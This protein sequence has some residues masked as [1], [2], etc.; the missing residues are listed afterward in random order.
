MEPFSK[1]LKIGEMRKISQATV[2]KAILRFI[3]H[4]LQPFSIVERTEFKDLIHD[5]Q[6]NCAVRSR[7]TIRSKI[8]DATKEMKKKVIEAMKGVEYIAT[9]TDCWS[10]RRRSFIG[11]TAHWIDPNDLNRCSAALAC[12]QLKGS[13]TFEVLANAL[14]DIHTQFE[15]R[16]KIVR[17][18][19]DNGSNFLKAFRVYGDE[20]NNT[21]VAEA[22]TATPSEEDDDDND[23]QDEEEESV[24]TDYI[25][26]A[27]ILDNADGFEFQLP[28]HQRCAC[29]LLNLISTVDIKSANSNETYKKL[30]R[31][32][33]AKCYALWNKSARSTT[34][35]EKVEEECSLQ[36]IR[37][38][39]TR[40]NSFFLSVERILKI[41]KDKGEG[42]I[43][44]VCTEFKI[45]M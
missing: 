4:G 28:K 43:R 30:S 24:E 29:H 23:P 15:I 36:F 18:T 13:H 31:S 41:M 44:A 33:F 17:T 40:W 8:E 11:L 16:E 12:R 7:L 10:S 34:A 2:D 6:P 38:N 45:P 20:N 14:H 27:S 25:E 3:V 35:A 9:T 21:S 5:L 26:V 32:S 19:T 42:A 1:Q 39:A 37:P 22:A